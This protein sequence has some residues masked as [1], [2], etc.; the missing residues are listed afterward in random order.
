MKAIGDTL[1]H[2]S[3]VS[4]SIYL[5][6]AVDDL[7]AIFGDNRGIGDIVARVMNLPFYRALAF[8]LTYC[9]FVTPFAMALGFFIALAVNTMPKLLKGPAIFVSILP[10]RL[11]TA[12]SVWAFRSHHS[13]NS[14]A[15]R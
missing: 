4:T 7:R 3:L 6:L 9:F 12:A 1:G 10:M 2:R 14:S 13:R 5:R 15:S 8:T 11:M